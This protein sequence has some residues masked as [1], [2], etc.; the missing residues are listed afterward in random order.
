M[1]NYDFRPRAYHSVPIRPVLS[2]FVHF[3]DTQIRL[4]N[5]LQNQCSRRHLMPLP[6]PDE[7]RA[8][9]LAEGKAGQATD[10]VPI[11]HPAVILPP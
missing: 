11:G 2:L 3:C 6:V 7:V 5:R 4:C 10:L 8:G 1:H 9:P